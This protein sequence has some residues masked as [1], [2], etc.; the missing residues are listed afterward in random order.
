MRRTLSR[1]LTISAALGLAAHDAA[2]QAPG[3]TVLRAAGPQYEAHGVKR[4]LGG[5]NWRDAWT[6]PVR[7]PVLDVRG[8]RGGLTPERRGGGNQ[9]I[10][11]HM[12]DAEGGR[13]IFRSIDKYPM[14][15][16]PPEVQNTPAGRIIVDHISILHPGGH[17]VM[18]VLLEA[19][20]ILHVV[21]ELYVMPDDAALGEH[22]EAFAGMLGELEQRPNEGPDDS[23]RFAGSRKIK[24][25]DEFFEDLD[26]S[27][28]HRLDEREFFAA[29]LI[30]FLVGDPDRGTDQWRWAR[31]GEK[32]A[33]TWRPVPADRDWAFVRGDGPLARLARGFYPKIATFGP[34]YPSIHTLTYSSHIV[35]RR[36]LT[37]LARLDAAVVA[38]EVRAAITDSVIDAAV[39]ALPPEYAALHGPRM[40]AAL[41][42]RRDALP[43]IAAEFYAWLASD[44]DV[45][46]TDEDD[47]AEIERNE[48]GSVLVRVLPRRPALAD[49][50]NGEAGSVVPG[51]EPRAF[52]ERVFRPG[53][54]RE[55]RVYLLGGDDHARV[56]GAADGPI[57][58]R[59]IGGAGDDLL[60]DR[61]GHA[62]LY[63]DEGTD[64]VRARGTRVSTKPWSAPDPPEGI[65]AGSD[66]APEWGGSGGFGVAYDIDDRAGVLLGPRA[67]FRRYGFRRLPY[68]W[69]LDVR[70]LLSPTTRGARGELDFDY[71]LQNS[72]R[73]ATV[74]VLASSVEAFRFYGFGNDSPARE[75][76]TARID[77]RR[78]RI[79]PALRWHVGERRSS[80]DPDDEDEEAGRWAR[81]GAPWTHGRIEVGPVFDW[82]DPQVPALSAVAD[83]AAVDAPVSAL[84]MRAAFD[85]RHTDGSDVP[86][87]GFR[88]RGEGS[89]YPVTGGPAGSF[90]TVAL[91]GSTYIPLLGDGP[92]L[93]LR[94]GA[95]RAFGEFPLFHAAFLGGRSTLRGTPSDRYAGDTS[96]N[97]AAEL[98]VPLDTVTLLVR[99][100]VGVFAFGDAG[101]VWYDGRS[102]GGWHT[103]HGAGLWFSAFG[104]AVSMAVARG[105][106][107]R[108]HV[109]FGLPF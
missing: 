97:G 29:R 86:R 43:R 62:R 68:R 26:E 52:Y 23:P 55:V 39:A 109:W 44:V 85:L 88:L 12:R 77:Y 45:R 70:A 108:L 67:G 35:D 48:D 8:F 37:R 38:E 61:A 5:A 63:D 72:S 106:A 93:A 27:H 83:A 11:L 1:L 21:P 80:G 28:G 2:A 90:G 42:A 25:T 64:F 19:A 102:D 69:D 66:W 75:R 40:A 22:R 56:T 17:F 73:S 87:R 24:G 92:H 58:V 101:R 16:L 98:R 84:G 81:T 41:R 3:D 104:R 20:G 4:A 78:L 74:A 14:R 76:E 9:S 54:T 46:G 89:A 57:V 15:A 96:V 79:T 13:W 100:E 30:D 51:A 82:T 47:L 34:S 31:F 49:A 95:K 50:T 10:T 18:P 36:L 105:E 60:E 107:T 33:Y 6:A 7:V 91:R 71:R 59:I 53:E 65:R 103:G 32:G 99:T 94:A